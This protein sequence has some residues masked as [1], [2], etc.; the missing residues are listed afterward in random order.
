MQPHLHRFTQLDNWLFEVKRV[1]AVRR[2]PQ[3]SANN[4]LLRFDFD[5]EHVNVASP[6]LPG[7][8]SISS[9]DYLTFYRF[10]QQLQVQHIH[11]QKLA[12]GVEARSLSVAENLT[13]NLTVL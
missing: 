10:C 2:H 9:L 13:P 12:A 5:E 3:D 4:M 1:Q 7:E 6:V 8:D 11:Y